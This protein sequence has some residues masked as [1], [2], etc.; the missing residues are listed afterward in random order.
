MTNSN[1][2]L[3][4]LA[5]VH[6]AVEGQ[7]IQYIELCGFNQD[8]VHLL[9]AMFV[10]LFEDK[11]E[12]VGRKDLSSKE[13]PF[14]YF[15]HYSGTKFYCI[16]DNPDLFP[17]YPVEQLAE[18]LLTTWSNLED[19]NRYRVIYTNGSYAL[20]NELNTDKNETV[21]YSHKQF[22]SD[23]SVTL[24]QAILDHMEGVHNN[25]K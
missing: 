2:I 4:N 23:E 21:I 12:I 3:T 5:M 11:R 13:N 10:K 6:S 7:H 16:T 22:E 20:A 18:D 9:E 25:G 8:G 1:E 19:Q 17:T 14:M 15:T 24:E